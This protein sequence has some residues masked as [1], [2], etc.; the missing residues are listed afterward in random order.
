L[1]L[2]GRWR[3]LGTGSVHEI[4]ENTPVSTTMIVPIGY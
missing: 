4:D 2:C 3:R 1:R